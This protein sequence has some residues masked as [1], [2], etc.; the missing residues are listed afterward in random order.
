[1]VRI[2]WKSKIRVQNKNAVFSL[3]FAAFILII[4]NSFIYFADR[5]AGNANAAVCHQTTAWVRP[6]TRCLSN[7]QSQTKAQKNQLMFRTIFD[8]GLLV[9]V[10]QY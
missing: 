5:L 8:V 3:F 10:W 2:A 7:T 6:E 4:P 1:M 9:S